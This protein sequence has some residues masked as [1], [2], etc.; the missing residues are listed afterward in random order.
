MA[1][2]FAHPDFLPRR[3]LAASTIIALH[4]LVAYLLATGLI[5]TIDL[6][7]SAPTPGRVN[8]ERA[9]PTPAPVVRAK[10]ELAAPKIHSPPLPPPPVV[11]TPESPPDRGTVVD[12]ESPAVDLAGPPAA[13]AILIQGKNVL[14]ATVDYYP[15]AK[16]R[17][18]IEGASYVRVCVDAE[19]IRQGEPQLE[20]SSGDA[21]L[22]RGALN[23]A[24]HGRYA[25]SLRG[26]LPVPNCYH[27]RIA[28]KIQ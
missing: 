7:D 18:G 20:H 10:A 8:I 25:R 5:H 3:A 16:R 17:E 13:E 11:L 1:Y 4:V 6:G 14:P 2:H 27:F 15:P 26:D 12:R 23:I 24:R 9:P 21:E 22:D 19:G 28:F